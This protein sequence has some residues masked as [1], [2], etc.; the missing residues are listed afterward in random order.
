MKVTFKTVQGNKFELDLEPSEK[1]RSDDTVCASCTHGV[2]CKPSS[3]K[4][5]H[6]VF[7]QVCD[8][9]QKIEASQGADFAAS[10]QVI[11]YQGKVRPHAS[12]FWELHSRPGIKASHSWPGCAGPEG[13]HH[14][15]G[16]QYHS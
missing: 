13:R 5:H 14:S 16:Q 15:G 3:K 12:T 7:G 6:G 11:I 2:A 1:V 4:A 9:K 10:Q 8:V